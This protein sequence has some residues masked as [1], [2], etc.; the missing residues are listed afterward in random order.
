MATLIGPFGIRILLEFNIWFRDF[1]TDDGTFVNAL[2]LLFLTLVG[3]LSPVCSY[4]EHLKW[5]KLS[6][7]NDRHNR[8]GSL[9]HELLSFLVKEP[10]VTITKSTGESKVRNVEL[11][12]GY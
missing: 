11:L 12:F 8:S 1:E 5:R 4:R 10:G 6:F 9:H 7:E 2:N 3:N